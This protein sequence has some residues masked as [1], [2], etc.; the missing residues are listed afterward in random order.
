M[1]SYAYG[2]HQRVCV[3]FRRVVPES[4][5]DGDRECVFVVVLFPVMQG[6]VLLPRMCLLYWKEVILRRESVC[7]K[8]W[9]ILYVKVDL[10]WCM[11]RALPHK[12]MYQNIY[13]RNF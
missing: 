9:G 8:S 13:S 3:W 7:L 10:S 6:T 1:L 5:S 4:T 2:V 11:Q 12:A